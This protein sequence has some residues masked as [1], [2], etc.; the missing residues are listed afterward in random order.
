M[1]YQFLCVD[2]LGRHSAPQGGVGVFEAALGFKP[3]R[4]VK[5]HKSSLP[6]HGISP[7]VLTPKQHFTTEEKDIVEQGAT[8]S[9]RSPTKRRQRGPGRL[10]VDKRYNLIRRLETVMP[11]PH[12]RPAL[13]R[14]TG[15]DEHER[16]GLCWYGLCSPRTRESLER[17]GVPGSPAAQSHARATAQL[18]S[19]CTHRT[20]LSPGVM[21]TGVCRGFP[22]QNNR[23]VVI[24]RA[25]EAVLGTFHSPMGL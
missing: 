8:P 20:P 11:P 13:R 9:D 24:N 12:D 2:G 15:P 18:K 23:T 21:N 19:F 25:P 14:R 5:G 17:G 10:L 3:R 22:L 1:G 7:V 6:Q 4:A 16:G